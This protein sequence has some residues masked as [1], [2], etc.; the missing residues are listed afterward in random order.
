MSLFFQAQLAKR[1]TWAEFNSVIKKLADLKHYID[2]MAESVFIGHREV[3]SR[4][5]VI[6]VGFL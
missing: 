5:G 4:W 3:G 1:I 6:S 2:T